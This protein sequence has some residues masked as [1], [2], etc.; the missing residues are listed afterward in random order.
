MKIVIRKK[1]ANHI[2]NTYRF[3]QPSNIK[4]D[5]NVP[6]GVETELQNVERGQ[7]LLKCRYGISR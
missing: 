3:A 5:V 1:K 4:S 7:L 6:Q 2:I